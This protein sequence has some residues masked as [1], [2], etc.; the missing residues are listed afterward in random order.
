MGIYISPEEADRAKQMDLFTYLSLAQPDELIHK[1]SN[2]YT[3][4]SH[5]SL[6]ISN[7]FWKRWSTG[8]GG[9]TAVDYL[10]KVEGYSFQEA[11]QKV[12]NLTGFQSWDVR[13]AAQ[14]KETVKKEFLLPEK[15]T[16]NKRVIAYLKSRGIHSEV[17]QY[18]IKHH[19]LYEENKNHNAVFVGYDNG[20]AKYAFRRGT[21][22]LDFKR[23]ASGS[24]KKYGFSIAENKRANVLHVYECAIDLLSYCSMCTMVHKDWRQDFH[25]SQGGVSSGSK[26][27]NIGAALEEFLVKHPDVKKVYLRYDNDKTGYESAI[28]TQRILQQKYGLEAEVKLPQRGKDYNEYLQEVLKKLQNRER[29]PSS[30]SFLNVSETKTSNGSV[31]K[32][33][34]IR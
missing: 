21:C 34:A 8:D 11:I 24:N 14:K 26:N 13:P 9:K 22:G 19:S 25:L 6:D 33:G 27:E 30:F 2:H 5:D 28:A 16:D 10:I 15:N 18:C 17:I 12:N 4:K 32:K 23:E 31:R 29:P 1:G 7:G 20:Q 3:T